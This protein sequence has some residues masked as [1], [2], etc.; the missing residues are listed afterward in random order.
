MCRASPIGSVRSARH[1]FLEIAEGLD[2]VFVHWG[3]SVY[4]YDALKQRNVDDIDGMTYSNTY[5]IGIVPEMWAWNILDA[6]MESG[7][8]RHSKGST[9]GARP[10][11]RTELPLYL[12]KRVS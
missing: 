6:R 11:R 12:R 3:G 2:A 10:I 9:L 8:R 5:F 4:A 1:D 7:L